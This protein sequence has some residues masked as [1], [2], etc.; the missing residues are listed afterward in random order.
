MYKLYSWSDCHK[1]PGVWIQGNNRS[2]RRYGRI[3][4]HERASKVYTSYSTNA[5]C[6]QP[7]ETTILRCLVSMQCIALIK[8]ADGS[9]DF[10]VLLFLNK[11]RSILVLN[12]NNGTQYCFNNNNII[13]IIYLP[14][15]CYI[16]TRD[17][18]EISSLRNW[19]T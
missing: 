8:M 19:Y 14:S 17:V 2:T 12:S 1:V 13:K 9:N 10:V 6:V 4:L 18:V 15:G 11:H 5:L 7:N 16:F 3:F